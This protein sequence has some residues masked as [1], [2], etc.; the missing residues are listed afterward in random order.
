M[1]LF[2]I[3][4]K[5]K[6]FNI[7]RE[8]VQPGWRGASALAAIDLMVAMKL[9]DTLGRHLSLIIFRGITFQNFHSDRATVPP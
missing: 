6:E 8:R 9:S 1:K 4:M 7:R 5:N 3:M 2:K